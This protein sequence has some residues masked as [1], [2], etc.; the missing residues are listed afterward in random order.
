MNK[1]LPHFIFLIIMLI[2][3][4]ETEQMSSEAKNKTAPSFDENAFAKGE[5]LFNEQCLK[6]HAIGKKDGFN[7]NFWKQVPGKNDS[8]KL[9]WFKIYLSNSDSLAKS[10]D[11]NAVALKDEYNNVNSH[12]HKLSKKE[13]EQIV[14]YMVYYRESN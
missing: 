8:A 1:I 3:C 11:T 14:Y 4:Q 5:S 10:G 7:M 9:E 12:Q 2:A 6:C 13:V